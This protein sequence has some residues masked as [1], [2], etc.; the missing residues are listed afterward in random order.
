MNNL[1]PDPGGKKLR[2]FVVFK[3]QD[4]LFGGLEASPVA[5]KYGGLTK[6]KNMICTAMEV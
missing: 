3:V 6:V 1:D 2:N 5:W 4:V